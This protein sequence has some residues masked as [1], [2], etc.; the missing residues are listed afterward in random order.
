MTLSTTSDGTLNEVV[1]TWLYANQSGVH[2][3]GSTVRKD[4]IQL[5]YS[6]DINGDSIWTHQVDRA[7]QAQEVDRAKSPRSG[8]HPRHMVIHPDGT[9][10]YIVMEADN[11]VV[12]LPLQESGIAIQDMA[13]THSI[14]PDGRSSH[15]S[16]MV[17]LIV[18]AG[19]NT[20]DYWSA[21]VAISRNKR[22]LWATSRARSRQKS[23]QLSCFL[24]DGDGAIVKRMFMV[25]TET[26]GSTS[27]AI[28]TAPWSDEHVVLSDVPGGYVQVWKLDG[29]TTTDAGVL[30]STAK[31][32]AKLVIREGA[33]CTNA[34]WYN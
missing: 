22:Y 21:D 20:A 30:Y 7:G 11:S 31:A 5:L 29:R 34:I 32:A 33:C 1:G 8:M 25:P 10:A 19:D 12:A 27:N 17:L 18:M 14:I 6:A 24:L 9:Y 3:L 28:S 23:G 13:A 15:F 16:R 26:T 4:G 2:G